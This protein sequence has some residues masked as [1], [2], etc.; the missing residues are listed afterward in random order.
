ML[1][2][3][4]NFS[5][6]TTFRRQL[7][8]SV[9]VGIFFLAL[10]SSL[11]SSWQGSRRIHDN[12]VE[13]G[14]RIAQNLATQ[15]KLALLY[16]SAENAAEAVNVTLAFPDITEVEIRDANGRALLAKGKN[17][18]PAQADLGD[19][20]LAELRQGHAFVERE[21]DDFWSFIAPVLA[22]GDQSPFEME[23][24]REQLLGYVR[25]IQSK[26]TLA[27][28]MRDVFIANLAIAFFF[29]LFFLLAIRLLTVRLTRPLIA[30]S[31]A[32]AK[33]ERGESGVRADER[34][35]PKDIATMAHAFNNMMLAIQEKTAAVER[36]R[37]GLEKLVEAR[38]AELS[39]ANAELKSTNAELEDT[40]QQ[41]LQ[42]EKLASI[43]Q[44]AAGVAHEIN[45]PI[46][47]VNANL[48]TLNGYLNDLLRL[49][50]AYEQ[51]ET[52]LDEH[53]EA[54]AAIDAVKREV[55]IDYLKGDIPELL[56]ESREGL[57][58]VKKIVLDLREFSHLGHSDWQYA[59]LHRGLDSTLNVV[60]N[61][62]KY[63]ADVIK[64]YGPL[65]E[66]E[67]LS[68]ELNQVFLNIL[69][70]AGHAIVEQGV[71]TIRT[72]L[73]DTQVWIEIADTGHGIDP[74]HVQRIFDPFFP[75]KPIGHGTGLGL[76]LSYGIVKRHNGRIEV[77]SEQGRG[78]LF[79]IVL[80][81]TQPQ[82][83]KL[84]VV[85]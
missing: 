52:L 11:A 55:E 12:L 57:D 34:A 8:V 56:S 80:P 2:P 46:G 40:H 65:P 50:A 19:L 6:R 78:T 20:K 62:L 85:K 32:M 23:E 59:D 21:G 29:A 4:A 67:C 83:P 82:A 45:N 18:A 77:E 33:A 9:A 48:G 66:I 44:L 49:L 43:G 79:R 76:S 1:K 39:D 71:I 72:G 16:A 7:S 31:D 68:S 5:H 35:G 41:L 15:S 28:M 63:K 70:N 53:A 27:R 38:T 30:L 25:V 69:V 73:D 74:A 60:W 3:L 47:F 54:R 36:Y 14:Q 51:H 37:H 42:S 64:E 75:T 81:L 26:D 24:R 17:A 22:G 58:R 61:E 84:Q 10:C 13:Q